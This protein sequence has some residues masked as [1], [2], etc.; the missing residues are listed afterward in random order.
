MASQKTTITTLIFPLEF[1]AKGSI[2]RAQSLFALAWFHAIIQERRNFIPQGW[3]KFYEFS[4]ADLRSSGDIIDKVTANN[5]MPEWITVHGLLENAIYG[6]RVDNDYDFR[7]LHTYLQMYFNSDVIGKGASKKLAKSIV[8]PNNTKYDDFMAIINELPDVDN[9]ALFYLPPNIER[10]L[11][12]T[13]SNKVR[14][15]IRFLLI[16]NVFDCIA[17]NNVA[18]QKKSCV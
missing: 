7:V 18:D 16:S 17:I 11:Q 6:G 15:H 8:L 1:V 3:S 2:L 13:N 9:P 12:I 5:A 14:T 4:Y 10:T